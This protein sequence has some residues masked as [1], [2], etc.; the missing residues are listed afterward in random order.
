MVW[1][2]F[3]TEAET[4]PSGLLFGHRSMN[5]LS[6]C[7]GFCSMFMD[8]IYYAT[9]IC[10]G[11][12]VCARIWMFYAIFVADQIRF[13]L[14]RIYGRSWVNGSRFWRPSRNQ[15]FRAGSCRDAWQ[16]DQTQRV[17][18]PRLKNVVALPDIHIRDFSLFRLIRENSRCRSWLPLWCKDTLEWSKY[19]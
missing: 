9:R 19:L 1:A 15:L 10:H 14:W 6:G 7:L 5:S 11:T 3:I 17:R 4:T 16:V 2:D 8:S 12:M 13:S 18:K